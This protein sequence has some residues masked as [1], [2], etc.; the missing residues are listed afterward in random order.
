[1]RAEI[2][3]YR[4]FENDNKDADSPSK[5]IEEILTDSE[6]ESDYDEEKVYKIFY[7]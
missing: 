2:K 4:D 6:D 5:N 3:R 1:M 7:F